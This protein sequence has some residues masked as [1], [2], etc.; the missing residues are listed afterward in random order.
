MSIF[1]RLVYSL[2]SCV[3]CVVPSCDSVFGSHLSFFVLSQTPDCHLSVGRECENMRDGEGGR[4]K[5]E[6][7]CVSVCVSVLVPACICL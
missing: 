5:E 2:S 6:S 7:V 1:N 4:R 3:H